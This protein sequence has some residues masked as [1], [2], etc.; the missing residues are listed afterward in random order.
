MQ[1][2]LVFE[3]VYGIPFPFK[4]EKK[5][6]TKELRELLFSSPSVLNELRQVALQED[7]NSYLNAFETENESSRYKRSSETDKQVALAVAFAIMQ[8]FHRQDGKIPSS[9]D[10]TLSKKSM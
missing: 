3:N 10:D 6:L 5:D 4:S 1:T 8:H 9:G 7:N 2:F